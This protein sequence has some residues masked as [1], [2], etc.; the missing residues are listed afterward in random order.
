VDEEIFWRGMVCGT[1]FCGERVFEGARFF[2]K[3]EFNTESTEKEHRV[4]RDRDRDRDRDGHLKVA[5]TPWG[6][7]RS[8][9]QYGTMHSLAGGKKET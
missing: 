7:G 2:L 5:A 1:A 6:D 3:K 9:K 8:E 4:H